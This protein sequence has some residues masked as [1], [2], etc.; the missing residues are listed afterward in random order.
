VND[1]AFERLFLH[2]SDFSGDAHRSIN[3]N[4][5]LLGAVD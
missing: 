3:A 4:R 5:I 2:L 1:S